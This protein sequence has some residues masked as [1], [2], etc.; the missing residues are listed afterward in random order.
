MGRGPDST[1]RRPSDYHDVSEQDNQ[2]VIDLQQRI[3]KL[4]GRVAELE[5]KPDVE[6]LMKIK[7]RFETVERQVK[8]LKHGRNS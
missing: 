3:A 4:E 8:H 2:A 5:A 1:H 6:I 7:D